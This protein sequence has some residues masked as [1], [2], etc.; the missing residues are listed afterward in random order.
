MTKTISNQTYTVITKFE[1]FSD[2]YILDVNIMRTSVYGYHFVTG[3]AV[4]DSGN[5]YI[6]FDGAINAV[7]NIL[8]HYVIL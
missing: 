1:L 2:A 8:I 7:V 6:Y 5:L 4:D 3:H